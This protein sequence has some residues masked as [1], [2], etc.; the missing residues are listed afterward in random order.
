MQIKK[1]IYN[2]AV[3]QNT[4][5]MQITL[6]SNSLQTK[7]IFFGLKFQDIISFCLVLSQCLMKHHNPQSQTPYLGLVSVKSSPQ[8]ITK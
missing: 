2:C 3:K 1:D 8:K 7:Y 4:V 6:L 5:R